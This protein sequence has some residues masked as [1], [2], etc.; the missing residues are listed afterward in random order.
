MLIGKKIASALAVMALAMGV[1]AVT[2]SSAQA[3]VTDC[4]DV[5]QQ[6]SSE[7]HHCTNPVSGGVNGRT[8]PSTSRA[9]VE[10]IP[11]DYPF[12]IWSWTYG[13]SINGDNIWYYGAATGLSYPSPLVYVSGYYLQTG[14][15]PA[16]GIR[17]SEYN[18]CS[19]KAC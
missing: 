2:A 9:I 13:D 19:G 12:E 18:G 1:V 5:Y 6:P 14:K 16:S 10:H 7:G 17:H 15:D 8:G 11:S 4:S 3:A